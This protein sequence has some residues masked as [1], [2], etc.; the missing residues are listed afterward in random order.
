MH[1]S[2]LRYG[3]TIPC[4]LTFTLHLAACG[5]GQKDFGHGKGK[6]IFVCGDLGNPTA[7]LSL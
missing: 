2:R 1:I 5:G 3:L 4:I 7:I 6:E